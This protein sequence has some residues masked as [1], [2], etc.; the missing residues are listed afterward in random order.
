MGPSLSRYCSHRLIDILRHTRILL[1]RDTIAQDT[2]PTGHA[3]CSLL[4]GLTKR[5]TGR[6]DAIMASVMASTA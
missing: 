5:V 4:K 2:T 3:F 6:E 1:M